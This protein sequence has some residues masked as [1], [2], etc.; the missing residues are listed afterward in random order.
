MSE[1]TSKREFSRRLHE[2]CDDKKLPEHGRQ[3]ILRKEF[4]VSQEAARKWL[5][6]LSIPQYR[7]QLK[8]CEWGGV[9]FEWLMTGNGI[10]FIN[11]DVYET[12]DPQIIHVARQMEAMSSV[13]KT[14][15]VSRVD[16]VAQLI[17]KIK[18]NGTQ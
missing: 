4:K 12:A 15:S 7:L 18:G 17:E 13:G 10:K 5:E 6:G 9:K 2:L 11:A 1:D 14:E 8:I 16:G 3:T